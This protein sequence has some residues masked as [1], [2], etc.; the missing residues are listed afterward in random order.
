VIVLLATIGALIALTATETRGGE[1]SFRR[2][3]PD[4]T[5]ETTVL[6]SMFAFLV[7]AT[8]VGAEWNHG[9]LGSLLL[10]EPRRLRVFAAKL[11]ALLTA[12]TAVAL[13][14]F[15]F[16]IAGYFLLSQARSGTPVVPLE[17][18]RDIALAVAR[19]AAVAL[20]AGAVG[21]AIAFT[22]RRTAAAL[23]AAL[24]YV[25]VG[26]IGVHAFELGGARWLLS[27]QLMAWVTKKAEIW[28]QQGCNSSGYCDSVMV[29]VSMW[30]AGAYLLVVTLVLLVAAAVIFR[31]REVT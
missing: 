10:W 25:A 8:A 12:I 18:Q 22:A 5:I 3:M 13:V 9:T 28:E 31:R 7:G 23:G 26:E 4:S 27:S 16:G 20:A 19:G 30:P 29:T 24:A 11:A 6:L 21:F 2:A 15:T 14:A 1:F 17:L